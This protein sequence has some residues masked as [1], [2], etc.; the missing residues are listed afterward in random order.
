MGSPPSSTDNRIDL[1]VDA[2]PSLCRADLRQRRLRRAPRWICRP[3]RSAAPPG[4]SSPATA[5]R[6]STTPRE[7]AALARQ[8]PAKIFLALGRQELAPFEAAPQHA[9][10]IRSVDPVEP[11]LAVPNATYILA[12]GPF[13]RPTTAR[14]SKR[15][16]STPSSRRTAAA[17]PPMARSPRRESSASRFSSSAVRRCLTCRPAPAS[18][19]FCASPIK[20]W[21]L[22][23][24]RKARRVDQRRLVAALDDPRLRR[25]DD[26]AG[27]HVGLRGIRLSPSGVTSIFS[28]GRPAARPKITG[29]VAGKIFARSSNALPSCQ[30]RALL[31]GL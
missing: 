7:A 12:R 27:R 17:R 18:R 6:W 16:A 13:P 14:C 20:H 23:R 10:L 9:Y 21:L 2:H 29:V 22:S 11:P 5:G 26:H 8:A 4:S 25:A 19:R 31:I 3:S 24:I 30:G 15:T 28:S 1:L